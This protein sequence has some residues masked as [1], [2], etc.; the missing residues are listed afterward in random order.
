VIER[1]QELER[2]LAN[3]PEEKQEQWVSHFLN[4]LSLEDTSNNTSGE[5][6]WIGGRRPTQEEV[7]EAID[8]ITELS[9]G[10]ILGDDLTLK[11]LINEG[12]RY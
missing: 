5:R 2:K 9:K 10:N 1:L 4:E 8:T 3:L 7:E 12:R 6:Q 11:D